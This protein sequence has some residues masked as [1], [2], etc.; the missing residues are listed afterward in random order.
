MLCRFLGYSDHEKAY[1]FEEIL[2][3]RIVVSRDAQIM[4]D[5]FDGGTRTFDDSKMIELCDDDAIYDEEEN[6]TPD[7]DADQDM[8][9]SSLESRSV[10][11]RP[12]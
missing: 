9:E 6:S 11:E 4:E 8:D 5:T 1:R 10:N 12:Q 3:G 2:S 7:E